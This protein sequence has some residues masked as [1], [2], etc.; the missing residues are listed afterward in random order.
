MR[1][2]DR[3]TLWRRRRR[4]ALLVG[5]ASLLGLGVGPAARAQDGA[6]PRTGEELFGS[7]QLEGRGVGV[8]G[9]YEIEGMLPGGAPVLDLTIPE[10][11]ARFGSGP[12]GYGLAGLA[13]PGPLL[14]DLGVLASQAGFGSEDSVPPWPIRSEAF[15]PAGP[16][17]ADG[18]QGPTV[19]KV[20]TGDL[21][22]QVNASFPAIDAPPVVTVGSITSA[23]RTSI[24]GTL[25]V[26][27]TRVALG[28]VKVLGGV[29]AIDS[30]VTDLVAAH[31]G[32][33]GSTNGGTVA[34]G[35]RF[36]GLAATLTEDGL[37]LAEAPAAPGTTTPLDGVLG[38]LVGP[39]GDLTQPVQDLLAQVL[40]Q[41]VPQVDDVL[42]QAGIHLRI[43]DP[44]EQQVDSGAATR[45]STGLE[46]ILS[47]RGK[48][49]QA[50]VDLVNS[51]PAELKPS[52]GPIPNPVTFLAENHIVG[53]SLAPATV[54]ALASPPFPTFDV[55][56]PTD[57]PADPLPFD[58]GTTPDLGAPGFATPTAPLPAA[59]AGSVSPGPLPTEPLAA[60][61]GAIPA[62]LVAL[63]LLVSP[64]FGLGSSRLA[65][66]VLA[67]AAT[68]CPSGL[69][70]PPAPQRT[71]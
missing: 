35:V 69:D 58:P 50:L 32:T 7:Y 40:Q 17:E 37:V 29:I 54:S 26:T 30:L 28:D 62:I 23:V 47:F 36:L 56:L 4:L 63:A 18:S 39:L 49:Q 2:P 43:L 11:L 45:I 70:K 3:A 68:S 57:L 55:P 31:D 6:G 5:T 42:A 24:E 51:I 13:Y 46:L 64:L 48:E 33:T 21:G 67:G 44:Q 71:T 10:T 53:L 34:T 52:L 8:Q 25:A 14:A 65:D 19:Q 38:P 61:S 66:N 59:P 16:V 9:R 20:V 15:Y 1:S 27:R 41:A 12:T 22:V 60:A